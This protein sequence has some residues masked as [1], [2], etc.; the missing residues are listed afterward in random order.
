[1]ATQ[2]ITRTIKARLY[3]TKLQVEKLNSWLSLC[4]ELYNAGLQERRDAY[5]LNRVSISY[6]HQNKQLT[7]I[8]QIRTEMKEVNSQV[9]QDPLRRLDKAFK[10][11]FRRIKSGQK[12]GYPRF[13]SWKRYRSFSVS[14][15]RYKIKGNKFNLSRLGEMKIR[16]LQQIEGKLKTATIKRSLGKWYVTIAVECESQPLPKSGNE[17]GLDVGITSFAVMSDGKVFNNPRYFEGLQK[18]LRTAQ[19]KVARRKKG[20]NRR[21]K[22][23][24]SLRKIYGKIYNQRLDFH[25]KLSRV[26]VNENGL[27]AIEDLNI[28]GLSKGMLAKQVNDVGWGSFFNKLE[29]KAESADRKLIKVNPAGTSQTCICGESVPKTLAVRVHKCD[30]CGIVCDRDLMS[31][32][33]ILER[34]K[35]LP[36][37]DNVKR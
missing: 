31:A 18:K 20:S 16:G 19:R 25:H 6:P 4:C 23:V 13:K 9:L 7:E 22:A 21:R 5:K 8:K 10:A 15:H 35:T 27:I 11:F 30:S 3:P 12:T 29:Y 36:S 33:V 17:I 24:L 14:H 1:M 26:I 32:R 2:I 28:L 34:A 37:Y